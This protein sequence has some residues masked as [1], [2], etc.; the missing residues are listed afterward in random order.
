MRALSRF[1]IGAVLAALVSLAAQAAPFAYIANSWSNSLSVI[2][3]ATNA[4]IATVPLGG[5]NGGGGAVDT[6][7]TRFYVRR[8]SGIAVF[9]TTTRTVIASI[10]LSGFLQGVAVNPSDTRV[11]V[12]NQ[13][14][15]SVAVIDTATNAVIATVA[16][17]THNPIGIAVNPAGTRV[18]VANAFSDD[19]AVIDALTNTVVATVPV[20]DEPVGVAVNPAGTRVYVPNRGSGT[21]SVID[22]A[23]DTVVAT[24][25]AGG[26]PA[27]V[28]VSPDGARVYV[29]NQGSGRVSVIDTATNAVVAT[30]AVGSGPTGIDVTPT[31]NR[32]Y[33]ENALSDSVS[34]ID[35]ATNTVI[36]TIPVGR[37]PL[38]TGRFIGPQAGTAYARNYVQKTY[39]AYY[40][41][42][43][44]PA[45]LAYWA[46]RMDAEGGSLDAIIAAFGYSDE[47]NRRYGGLGNTALVT[48]I[49][50]QALGRDPDPVGLA[51][52]VD[53]LEA[54]RRTLQTI[55]LDVLN[56]AVTPPDSTVV[57]NK[58]DVAVYYT[59]K[60][61]AGCLYGTEQ[62]GVNVIAGVTADA[63]TAS[64][65]KAA[66]DARCGT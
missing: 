61:A 4:V 60:V 11:Y 20:G 63:A 7:G 54:G 44:D 1:L 36:A 58:L 42:P 25:A 21:V 12:A 27:F 29:T 49:Y 53:E 19:V 15:S 5:V 45:G 28:A 51:W 39:V 35:T 57:A 6:A 31:G 66:I 18:Y 40:G 48:K 22:T 32:V 37:V 52:Y 14:P 47:F 3:T 38:S 56:G 17:T 2:D 9:D 10:P 46:N 62:D 55:A 33:V 13:E 65:A 8:D 26:G 64:A 59:T 24:V 43:G 23:S 41:R 34:V 50:Q 16:L 30:V